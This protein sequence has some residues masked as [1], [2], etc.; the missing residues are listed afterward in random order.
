[1]ANLYVK[2]GNKVSHNQVEYLP[3]EVVKD[4]SDKEAQSLVD[5]GVVT[6]QKP[7]TAQSESS[8]EGAGTGEGGDH[9]PTEE[10]VAAAAA[11]AGGSPD[12]A[13]KGL[14]R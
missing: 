4:L 10:E 1:M 12:P 2:E 14:F 3:G 9:E 11:A 5:A 6:S 13:K 7:A 8:D